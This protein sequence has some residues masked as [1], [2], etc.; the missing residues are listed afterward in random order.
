MEYRQAFTNRPLLMADLAKVCE[1]GAAVPR[2]VKGCVEQAAKQQVFHHIARAMN[3]RP[4]D[5]PSI[6]DG[7][8]IE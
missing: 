7:K 5:F 2:T 6:V 1:I 4:D 8:D 3:I